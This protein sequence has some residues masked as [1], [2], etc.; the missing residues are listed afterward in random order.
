MVGVC[1]CA[2]R[3][4]QTDRIGLAP[5]WGP[6]LLSS[7]PLRGWISF[8]LFVHCVFIIQVENRCCLWGK[9]SG[10]MSRRRGFNTLNLNQNQ[11]I[12]TRTWLRPLNSCPAEASWSRKSSSWV[13]FHNRRETTQRNEWNTRAFRLLLWGTRRVGS[14]DTFQVFESP[15]GSKSGV[16]TVPVLPQSPQQAGE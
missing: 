1:K 7:R 11:R 6:R 8:L 14:L 10:D 9:I 16:L 12:K 3:S 5:L 4:G 13:L 15:P 2:V